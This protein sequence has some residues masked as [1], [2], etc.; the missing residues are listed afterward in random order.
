MKNLVTWLYD[1]FPGFADYLPP[2]L[3]YLGL[4]VVAIVFA[5]LVFGFV[6]CSLWWAVT[7]LLGRFVIMPMMDLLA[8]W[9]DFLNRL[10]FGKREFRDPVHP[11]IQRVVIVDDRSR[12][13]GEPEA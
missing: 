4:W 9:L 8:R 7:G 6:T 10:V 11:V 13:E 12:D 1:T 3:L 2:V 5:L